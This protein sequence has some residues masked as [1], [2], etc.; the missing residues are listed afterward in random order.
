MKK[1]N[2]QSLI[3][4]IL[5]FLSLQ[6]FSQSKEKKGSEK[7]SEQLI[8]IAEIEI[9][10]EFWE[11]YKEILVYEA[12]ASVEIED[13]VVCIFPM[14]IKESTYHIRILEIYANQKAYEDHLKSPHFLHYKNETLKMVK[15]LKLIDMKALDPATQQ[16]LFKKEK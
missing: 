3:I 11:E 4:L 16:L 9:V 14:E 13:G 7:G 12:K 1:A 15:D 5:S 8:R 2:K 6:G 10:P